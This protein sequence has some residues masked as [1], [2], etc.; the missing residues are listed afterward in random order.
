M[1]V[2]ASYNRAMGFSNNNHTLNNIVRFKFYFPK[3]PSCLISDAIL[4]GKV[5]RF[6]MDVFWLL[7]LLNVRP[8]L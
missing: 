4:F 8:S 6:S 5:D 7:Y 1:L 2:G 3:G